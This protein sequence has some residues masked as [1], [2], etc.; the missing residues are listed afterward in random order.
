MR[1]PHHT[2]T[3]PDKRHWT[4]APCR[5]RHDRNPAAP[6]LQ[7]RR[8]RQ[9]ALVLHSLPQHARRARHDA[10]KRTPSSPCPFAPQ[11]VV[12]TMTCPSRHGHPLNPIKGGHPRPHSEHHRPPLSLLSL[13]D[14][15]PS[16]ITPSATG[17]WPEPPRQ[18]LSDAVDW[19]HLSSSCD[20]PM[21]RRRLLVRSPASPT[22]LDAGKPS[23]VTPLPRPGFDPRR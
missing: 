12:A 4:P 10:R 21:P 5:R 23:V 6:V 15:I 19:R 2:R 7:G 17:I 3:S 22:P 14:H 20:H 1:T 11:N 13:P 18:Y 9:H 16:P 8:R